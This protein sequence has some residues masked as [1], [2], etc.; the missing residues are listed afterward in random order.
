VRH[1]WMTCVGMLA[2]AG[3]SLAATI[4]VPA[5][6]ATI[7]AAVNAASNGD[8]VIVAPGTYVGKALNTLGKAIT[9]K[10][11]GTPEVTIID[12]EGARRVITCENNEGADTV[13]ENFTITGDSAYSNLVKLSDNR[14]GLFYEKGGYATMTF[15]T[16]SIEELEKPVKS[17]KGQTPL[18]RTRHQ[19]G[20]LHDQSN[21]GH[22]RAQR[23]RS[24]IHARRQPLR[25]RRP[26]Q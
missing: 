5:D 3:T 4:N 18:G 8:E 12:G 16:M 11:S 10:A 7:Q 1:I 23:D 2:V 25:F 20:R 24:I 17:I 14:A 21:A 6:Y 15:V 22:R 13:I 26:Q 19:I 9:I